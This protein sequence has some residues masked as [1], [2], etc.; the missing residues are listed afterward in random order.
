MKPQEI[1]AENDRLK[2]ENEK[3]TEQLAGLTKR[4]TEL[5]S[6]KAPSKSKQMALA[7][8][9]LLEQ[10]PVGVDALAKIN[11]KYPSD[12]IYYVRTLLKKDVKLVRR[13]GGN[14]Y[15]LP[16]HHQVYVEGLA[17]EKAAKEA[18]EKEAKEAIQAA[19]AASHSTGAHA[20]VAV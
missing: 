19:Q 10:G 1:A 17:K 14:V 8:L 7:T 12:P 15:M 9:H 3:L 4:I 5:E 16:E 6:A 18:S 11:P 2:K 20:A 13:A